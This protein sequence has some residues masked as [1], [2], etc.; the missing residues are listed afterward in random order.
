MDGEGL[1][2]FERAQAACFEACDLLLPAPARREDQ[3]WKAAAL[4]PP[5]PEDLETR[6]ARESEV[7]HGDVHR[8]LAP[9]E[10][11]LS[12]FSAHIDGEP[13]ATQRGGDALAQGRLVLHQEDPH[14]AGTGPE[15]SVT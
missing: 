2:R 14:D 11:R 13:L 12:P 9:H 10:Q 8:I 6:E 5:T 4:G 1:E 7:Q 3:D 15:G